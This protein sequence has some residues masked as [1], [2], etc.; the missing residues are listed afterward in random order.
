LYDPLGSLREEVS[1]IRQNAEDSRGHYGH[2]NGEKHPCPPPMQCASRDKEQKRVKRDVEDNTSND[3]GTGH[4]VFRNDQT[5]IRVPNA[6]TNASLNRSL[7]AV[8]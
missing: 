6:V 3:F 7:I 2:G 1:A 5:M 8:H 4:R